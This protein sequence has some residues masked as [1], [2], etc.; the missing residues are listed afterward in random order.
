MTQEANDATTCLEAVARTSIGRPASCLT[1]I[2]SPPENGRNMA[3]AAN[4]THLG[5]VR[6]PSLR[7]SQF[8]TAKLAKRLCVRTF[9]ARVAGKNWACST[10]TIRAVTYDQKTT[11]KTPNPDF[12]SRGSVISSTS[13]FGCSSVGT[14]LAN[15]AKPVSPIAP[16]LIISNYPCYQDLRAEKRSERRYMPCIML[17]LYHVD[18]GNHRFLL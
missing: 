5:Q 7:L 6:D 14:S 4:Q 13:K 12:K 8:E 10:N 11:Y 3:D 9:S 17:T 2:R 18:C 1:A 16:A 15:T